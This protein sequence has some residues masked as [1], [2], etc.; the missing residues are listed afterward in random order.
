M[1]VGLL[2]LSA[3]RAFLRGKCVLTCE[4]IQNHEDPVQPFSVIV[5][6]L[7]TIRH[8]GH[9]ITGAGKALF[10]SCYFD[11]T[12]LTGMPGRGKNNYTLV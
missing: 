3:F 5:Y 9:C 11:R 12:A 10:R 6:G 8:A 2:N 4:V 1:N 7:C